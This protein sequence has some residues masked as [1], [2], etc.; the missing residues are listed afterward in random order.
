MIK[1]SGQLTCCVRCSLPD[2]WQQAL[3]S[4]RG[5]EG[6][7]TDCAGW[8]AEPRVPAHPGPPW[9]QILGLQDRAGRRK[10]RHPREQ[11]SFSATVGALSF[12]LWFHLNGSSTS[13]PPPGGSCPVSGRNRCSEDGGGV[14]QA[15]LQRHQQHQDTCLRV[16]THLG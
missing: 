16:C 5:Q 15:L 7:A 11:G 13:L 4:S 8:Q 2:R 9:V 14:S 6:G 3:G 12:S 10:P 1:V